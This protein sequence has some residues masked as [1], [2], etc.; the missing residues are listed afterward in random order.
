ML[1]LKST[2]PMRFSV[3]SELREVVMTGHK[4]PVATV[5]ITSTR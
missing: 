2:A 4:C 5:E 3:S 1:P